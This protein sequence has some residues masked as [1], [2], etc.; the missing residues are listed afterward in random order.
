MPK[1]KQCGVEYEAKRSTSSYCSPKCKQEF[2]RNRINAKP[3][4]VTLTQDKLVTV[5]KAESHTD[6][7]DIGAV[8]ALHNVIP[9][10]GKDIK[11]FDD[12]P[13]DVQQTID[14]MSVVEGKIDHT[15][16]VNRTAIAIHYQHLFPDRYYSTGVA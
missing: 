2:Y 12:L 10:R 13:P 4:I 15:L 14:K 11:T 8:K 9:K 7:S 3:E 1:C 16:K 6:A 5:I